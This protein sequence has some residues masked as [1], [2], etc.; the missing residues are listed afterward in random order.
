MADQG[1]LVVV[2]GASGAGKDSVLRYAAQTLAGDPRFVFPRRIITRAANPQNE[3]HATVDAGKFN[4]MAAAGEFALHWEAHELKYGVPASIV[5]DLDQ[6]RV[7]SVNV[8]RAIVAAAA[9]S[10]PQTAVAEVVAS[11]EACARRIAARGRESFEAALARGRRTVPRPAVAIPW[12][13]ID[14]NGPV[15]FAGES[16]C[17][18]LES[19]LHGEAKRRH[20]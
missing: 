12:F 6:G 7:V 2:V 5:G 19:L 18:F 4:V 10:F 13:K 20:A 15:E 8:S 16:F 11:P 14:N 17:S 9:A 1:H 3:D